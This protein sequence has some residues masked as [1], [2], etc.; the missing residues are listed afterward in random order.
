MFQPST[1]ALTANAVRVR[2]AA[3]PDPIDLHV[4]GAIR[5]RRRHLG[6]SQTDLAEALGLTFQQVQ[7]YE[8]GINRVSASMLARAAK[9]LSCRPGDL[10][11][12]DDA[13]AVVMRDGA[14]MS[15]CP[16][17]A[18]V[19]ATWAQL[20]AKARQAIRQTVEAFAPTDFD[21]DYTPA[22]ASPFEA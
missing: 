7:K 1:Q 5:A 3:G 12:D 11:P 18:V 10:F 19:L 2:G 6:M 20:P 9:A 16:S 21:A 15:L 22:P 8:R 17:G 13:D 4:G 14:A